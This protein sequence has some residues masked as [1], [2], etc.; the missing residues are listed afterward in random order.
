M[1][2]E[3][4][5]DSELLGDFLSG[6]N[7]AFGVFFKRHSKRL[8]TYAYAITKNATT[9]EEV[10]QRTL[11]KVVQHPAEFS[12][13]REMKSYLLRTA[14]N[15]A[16]DFINENEKNNVVDETPWLVKPAHLL[17]TDFMIQNDR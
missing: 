8:F 4:R 10:V 2:R 9:A 13:V 7:E 15:I 11:C 3:S 12:K 14:R 17:L 6:Q 16:L 1:Q 5:E